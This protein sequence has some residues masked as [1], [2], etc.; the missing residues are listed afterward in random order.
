MC[1]CVYVWVL[2]C[3]GVLEIRVLLFTVFLCCFVYVYLS[4]FVLSV[5]EKELLPP[6]DNSIAV[7]K[8]VSK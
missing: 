1:G 2:Q 6:S 7:C 3:V 4:L 5:L 8:L